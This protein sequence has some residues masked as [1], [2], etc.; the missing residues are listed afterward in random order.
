E[1]LNFN[2]KLDP[3]LR[4]R[5]IPDAMN[6]GNFMTW[7]LGDIIHSTPMTVAAPAEGYHL[8]YNDFSYA[9]FLRKYKNRRHVVYFGAND[10]ML[11][12]VNAGFY[13]E[14]DKKFCLVPL[15]SDGSCSDSAT[16]FPALGAEMWAYLP[17]NLQPHIKCLGD[18]NYSH[19]YYVDQRPRMFDA[20]IFE[21]EPSCTDAFGDPQFDDPNCIHP[22]GW[23]T[24]LVGGM[25][26]GGTPIKGAE[27]SADSTDQRLFASAY[28][29]MDIT[30]PE[31]V[32]ELLGEMTWK[33]DGSTVDLGY[34]ASIPTMVI[35]KEST[36][37]KW[38]LVFGSG[39]HDDY[40][41]VFNGTARATKGVS[42][43][44]AKVVVLPLD[45]LKNG[46]KHALQIPPDKPGVTE[47]DA[48]TFVPRIELG[49]A[50]ADPPD[51][52]FVSDLITVDYDI[53]PSYGQYKSDVVYF[54]TVEGDFATA[55]DGRSYWYGGGKMYRLVTKAMVSGSSQYG[56]GALEPVT[57]PSA[58]QIKPLIDLSSTAGP[59][60]PITA[61]AS[62]A[63]DHTGNFWIYFGTGRFFD[64]DDKTD[65][66]QQSY[67]GIKEPS[68]VVA[69]NLIKKKY[70]TWEEVERTGTPGSVPGA[71]GLLKVDDILVGVNPLI[72][73][74][75][76]VCQT[77]NDTSCLPPAVQTDPHLSALDK[78]I[79][80]T[81]LY[82]VDPFG[83]PLYPAASP[84]EDNCVDGWYRDF[85]PS[86][87]R[88]R[89]IGQATLL[90]GLVTYTTYKPFNDVCQAE[91]NAF[92]YAEYYR[93]GTAWHKNIFGLPE[94]LNGTY[95][96]DKLDLG[97]GLA[98][99]PNLHVG[100][101]DGTGGDDGPKA[102]V[103][104]STGEIKEIEQENLPIQNYRTG[105]SKWK[106]YNP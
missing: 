18:P 38:Y 47:P 78:Y 12:A 67:Y 53:N 64:A 101:G 84:C 68:M 50:A 39:P 94:G 103:Q 35:M 45:W 97:R 13:S 31:R 106:E 65:D 36:G 77:T 85:T 51:N 91:G 9:Q 59:N 16:D 29:I 49:G 17:Y 5:Q 100:S 2:L 6:S 79:A 1:E 4:E 86:N 62:V 95:V 74:A 54:G 44:D 40:A 71:K 81:R 15:G 104:T 102:F 57:L 63:T 22:N 32:P 60:Q 73:Q 23:G 90:G 37:S 20:Q 76:L 34:T 28:F 98:T 92:L 83:I 82:T 75:P 89:N 70:F 66:T 25:R 72:T 33:D 48:G 46:T 96:R 88:E 19:K 58:W 21:Q 43:Q 61:S 11:H 8:I 7:R 10:G 105:R 56:R 41:D 93:T 52:G 87:N 24:I 69:D 26:F 80:G 14:R 55:Y 3:A 99:T 30:D 27:L 42:D